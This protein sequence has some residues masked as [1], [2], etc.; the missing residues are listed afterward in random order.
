[1]GKWEPEDVFMLV[2]LVGL[3]VVFV[4]AMLTS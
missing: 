1:M 4:L 3:I 2:L